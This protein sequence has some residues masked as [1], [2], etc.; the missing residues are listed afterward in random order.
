MG[1]FG[2]RN[3]ADRFVQRRARPLPADVTSFF[4]GESPVQEKWHYIDNGQTVGPVSTTELL[5]CLAL[6]KIDRDCLVWKEGMANW[7]KLSDI[8]ELAQA[9][10][11]PQ[12]TQPA[13][14]PSYGSTAG[15]PAAAGGSAFPSTSGGNSFQGNG[16]AGF[17]AGFAAGYGA[18]YGGGRPDHSYPFADFAPKRVSFGKLLGCFGVQLA[19][20]VGITLFGFVSALR[21][22]ENP[23]QDAPTAVIFCVILAISAGLATLYCILTIIHRSWQAIQGYSG[24]DT[25][26]TAAVLWCIIPFVNLYGMFV[27]LWRWSQHY[28]DIVDVFGLGDAPDVN[29]NLFLATAICFALQIIP[30][31]NAIS[32]L[33]WM[34]LSIYTLW[35]MCQAV[36]YFVDKAEEAMRG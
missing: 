34:V 5:Q 19:S 4:W 26:P 12:Q 17:D 28:N 9:A 30:F 13:N 32:G 22:V 8:P 3:A 16:A 35:K 24:V 29:P 33:G 10:P 25:S 14:A 6:G 1:L 23:V 11:M 15:A 31:L 36:N 20:I 2:F 18:G 7:A 21:G 27:A